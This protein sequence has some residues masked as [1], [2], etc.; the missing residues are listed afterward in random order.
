MAVT[1]KGQEV[2][3][4]T[5]DQVVAYALLE[6]DPD[7]IPAYPI[8]PQT[9]I[10]EKFSEFWADGL[11]NTEL[12]HVESEHSAMSAAVGASSTGARVFTASSSQG[13][14]LMFEIL[15]IASGNRLPI[16]M[17]VANRALSSPI[18]IHGELTDQLITRDAGWISFLGEDAQEAYDHTILGF[19]IA[20]DSRILLPFMYGIEGFIVT[21]ALEPVYLL[22]RKQI[23]D[24]IGEHRNPGDQW[25]FQPGNSGASG[26]LAL[27]D[28]Y[29]ELKYQQ[30]LAMREAKKVIPKIL[31][32][33][34]ELT[35]R[36]YKEVEATHMED[37]EYAL[38]TAGASSGTARTIV[39]HLRQNG[40]KVGHIKLR[41]L[42]PF[43]TEQLSSLMKDLKG[44]MIFDRSVTFGSPNSILATEISS[45][46]AK[47][48]TLPR[49]LSS[50]IVGLGGR[51][52]T[53]NDIFGLYEQ[54]KKDVADDE[55][56]THWWGVRI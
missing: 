34:G 49:V 1:Q 31:E 37:A 50:A 8:T 21:H 22:E 41:S 55:S 2:K 33:F 29:M 28:F 26:M 38:I 51:D 12:V 44:A 20:E 4:L 54:L 30:E 47:T 9:I 13:I 39:N 25:V 43:P 46:L 52:I 36:Y 35:G 17:A 16:V 45:A 24:F 3:A 5:G 10:M 40:E 19:K 48:R 18:N 53:E 15:F 56:R 42:R 7:V 11:V 32:E 14:A 6:I 27:P 23:H